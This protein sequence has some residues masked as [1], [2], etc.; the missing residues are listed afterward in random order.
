MGVRKYV[1]GLANTVRWHRGRCLS[2]GE[3]VAFLE[4][5]RPG[6]GTGRN[7]VVL[8]LDPLDDA[9]MVTLDALVPGMPGRAGR[10]GAPARAASSYATAAELLDGDLDA[11]RVASLWELAAKACMRSGDAHRTIGFAEQAVDRYWRWTRSA[12]P[13]A[14]SRCSRTSCAGPAGTPMPAR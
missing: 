9:S 7:R 3:G 2:Y 14:A 1:D 8:T 12:R 13:P 11:V 10:T 4:E 6:F 5:V